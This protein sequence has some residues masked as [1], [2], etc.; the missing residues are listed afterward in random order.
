MAGSIGFGSFWMTI[1]RWCRVDSANSISGVL[2][3]VACR[4]REERCSTLPRSLEIIEA[5]QLLLER[6]ADVNARA[7]VGKPG[8]NGQTPIFHAATQFQDFGLSNGPVS[9]KT[10]C[11]S[12]DPRQAPRPLRASGRDGG[13]FASWLRADVSGPRKQDGGVSQ[14]PR[15]SRVTLA[16][17]KSG[18]IAGWAGCGRL[19]PENDFSSVAGF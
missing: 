8:L 12:V 13:M 2:P 18:R 10:R 5:A 19:R 7:E 16:A 9:R 17:D 3:I 1:R 14:G 15:R 6:G 4:S 11:G